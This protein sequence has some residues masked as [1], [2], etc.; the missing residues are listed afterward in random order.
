MIMLLLPQGCRGD[1]LHHPRLRMVL[2]HPHGQPLQVQ[3]KT[4]GWGVGCRESAY[5]P[6]PNGFPAIRAAATAFQTHPRPFQCRPARRDP[7]HSP[8]PPPAR[9]GPG[10]WAAGAGRWR[11]GLGG[12]GRGRA[13]AG[14][15]ARAGAGA[16]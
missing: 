6:S 12:S 5:T 9:P 11:R 7:R 4:P 2:S 1:C 14:A 10:V 8:G 16:G 3:F 15:R 13:G